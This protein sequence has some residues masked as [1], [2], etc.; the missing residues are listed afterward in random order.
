[1]TFYAQ[2]ESPLGVL[3]L[4]S[5]GTRLDGLYFLDQRDCPRPDGR[6]K[7][8][9][10]RA[11]PS[12]GM[13]SGQA[14]K[15]FKVHKAESASPGLFDDPADFVALADAS[16]K[17]H[18][19]ARPQPDGIRPATSRTGH[20]VA[21]MQAK[22]PSA[23]LAVFEQA[24]HELHAYFQGKLKTFRVPLGLNGTPFQ[25]KVWQALLDIPYGEYVSYG[26]VARAA[27]LTP[28]HSRPVGT[29]VGR[30]PITIIVPCHRVL[31]G[32]GRLNGYTGGL[33]RKFAL[34]ELE[35]FTLG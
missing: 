2:V 13:L 22:T 21:H 30:N 23:V 1:M 9:G 15:D 12:A 4:E 16:D 17:A 11:D 8:A 33:E 6:E 19:V 26:D 20:D 18:Q 3:L 27:G 31:A 7:T 35:G 14:I 29:A 28:G 24:E 25:R 34:L 10:A 32:N 5:H